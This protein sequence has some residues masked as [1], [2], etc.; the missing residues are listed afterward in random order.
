MAY[1]KQNFEDG[2]VLTAAE[3]NHIENGLVAIETSADAA[4]D[5]STGVTIAA[6]TL[7][8]QQQTQVRTNISAAKV[9]VSGTTMMIS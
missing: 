3:L 9:T 1:E 5:P 6:Q 7:T 2:N 8:Q 4:L